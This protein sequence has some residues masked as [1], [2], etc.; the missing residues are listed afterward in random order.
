M[1][2]QDDRTD[3]T[4]EAVPASLKEAYLTP[5][6]SEFLRTELET[7]KQ[8][9]Y[10]T[11]AA[12]ARRFVEAAN[13]A[14]DQADRNA[15]VQR[16]VLE[17]YVRGL[18]SKTLKRRLILEAMPDNVAQA[19]AAVEAFAAREECLKRMTGGDSC[20]PATEE[21]PM[22]IGALRPQDRPHVATPEAPSADPSMAAAILRLARQMEGLQKEM[23]KMKGNSLTPQPTPNASR[24]QAQAAASQPTQ[25]VI[26][27]LMPLK[28]PS[29]SP[30]GQTI[31]YECG[32]FGHIGKNCEQRRRRLAQSTQNSGNY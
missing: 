16:I 9:A 10:E 22:E 3:V 11:L 32:G 26:P 13:V 24:P 6:E 31:C 18:R 19:I 15:V 12:Y 8:T 28:Y 4:W 2:E 1:D 23:T 27:P 21:T 7:I 25:A 20:L 17:R 30:D 14:Y 29:H 5:D